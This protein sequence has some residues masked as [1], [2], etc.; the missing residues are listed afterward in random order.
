MFIQSDF[1]RLT[2]Y[3]T[4]V[5]FNNPETRAF[6]NIVRKGE[7]AGNQHFLLFPTMFSTLPKPNLN[8][9][10]TCMLSSAKLMLSIWTSLSLSGLVKSLIALDGVLIAKTIEN[11]HLDQTDRCA[12]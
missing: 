1:N 7:N 5:T 11:A 3:H 9:S 2:L 4:I 6:E 12:G 10:F 8:F